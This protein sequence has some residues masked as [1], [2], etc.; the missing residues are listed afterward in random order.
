[1]YD[2]TLGKWHFWLS[3]IFFNITFFPMHFLGLAGMPRRIPDY[4]LQFADFNMIAIDR[5]VRLRPVAAAVPVHRASSASRAARRRRP[6]RGK[7]RTA[8][9][10]TPA[11]AG[12]VPQLRDAAGRSS[13]AGGDGDRSGADRASNAQDRA[14]SWRRSRWCSSSAIV[15]PALVAMSARDR[16]SPQR[17]GTTAAQAAGRRGRRCSASASRWCR[18]TS[19]IC[20]VTGHQQRDQQADDAAAR[21]RRSTPTRTVTIEFD[22]NLRSD[23]PWTF[24]PRA[25]AACRCIPGELA[26]VMY[27]VRNTLDR[28]GHRA[29]DPELRP[30]AGGAVFQEARVLLLHAADARS[31]ARRGRCRWCS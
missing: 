25:D 12:A 31:R 19:K 26:Q 27:E 22:A 11:L 3:M 8:L 18:S 13:N 10:W 30:A 16:R 7:A 17:T 1:M 2:E 9:E 14:R 21:T 23:L 20:E 5:R 28:A 24:R 6:S 15:H 4:A 29:G